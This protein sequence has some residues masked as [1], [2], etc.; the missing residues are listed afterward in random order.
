[1]LFCD[2]KLSFIKTIEPLCKEVLYCTRQE[3]K[4]A[5][6]SKAALLNNANDLAI[7]SSNCYQV[8]GHQNLQSHLSFKV[9]WFK[10][11]ENP[12]F[13]ICWIIHLQLTLGLNSN[14]T[15]HVGRF[16]GLFNDQK[17]NLERVWTIKETTGQ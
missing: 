16:L 9:E 5:T 6:N 3:L 1:M 2:C 14:S 12:F 15:Q 17:W 11:L 13:T 4:I 8:M 7:L 10:K